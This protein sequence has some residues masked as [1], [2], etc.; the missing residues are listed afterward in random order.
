MLDRERDRKMKK[1]FDTHAHYDDSAFE[2]D[3]KELI[4][5]LLEHGIGYVVNV[6][7]SIF[8]S[9]QTLELVKEY[10]FF[11]GA[12]GVHPSEVGEL[13]EEGIAFLRKAALKERVVA[14]GEIGLDYYWDKSEREVQKKW[15]VRQLE[16]ARE[17]ELP[18]II[19]SRDAAQDT[20]DILKEQ[21]AEEIGGVIHCFSYSVEVAKECLNMGFYLGIGGVVTFPNAKKL[22]EVVEMAPLERIVLETDCPYLAPVPNRGKRNNSIY[23]SYVAEAIAQIKQVTYEDVVDITFCNA[24]KLYRLEKKDTKNRS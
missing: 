12:V 19:H 15:F 21:K 11:Y 4:A 13:T 7:A 20:M 24:K 2:D 10:P 14:I 18:V 22:Q 9:K 3:R 17:V 16:L 5:E 23:L 8:S 1:I 6:G